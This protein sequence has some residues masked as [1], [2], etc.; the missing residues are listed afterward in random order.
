MYGMRDC[1]PDRRGFPER[2]ILREARGG[3]VADSEDPSRALAHRRGC[4]IALLIVDDRRVRFEWQWTGC[5]GPDDHSGR[6]PGASAE[7]SRP[8]QGEPE[9][10]WARES[11]RQRFGACLPGTNRLGCAVICS[12]S[13]QF[14]CLRIAFLLSLPPHARL[15]RPSRPG[16]QAAP[17]RDT[18][19]ARDSSRERG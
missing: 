17:G 9:L 16:P 15:R 13:N 8:A 7:L 1:R 6:R 18:P 5:P 4:T 3:S 10:R 19:G 14:A 2:R 12:K 11:K